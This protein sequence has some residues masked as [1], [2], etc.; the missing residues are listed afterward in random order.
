M[1][2]QHVIL[3]SSTPTTTRSRLLVRLITC[4]LKFHCTAW[5][6]DVNFSLQVG[7]LITFCGSG[8]SAAPP[9]S[10]S[11]T[12][13]PAKTSKTVKAPVAPV[14]TS[15]S[16]NS[17]PVPTPTDAHA[18]DPQ[19]PP[20]SSPISST[21]EPSATPSV[22]PPKCR[23]NPNK[24]RAVNDTGANEAREL[25]DTWHRRHQARAAR[26]SNRHH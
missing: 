19:A 2:L 11:S 25:Y 7:L 4:A 5:L 15:D 9:A 12:P 26:L 6:S 8:D 20:S 3:R 21:V 10:K 1:I 17:T 22:S 13:A 23:R 14:T 24:R 16:V 18:A